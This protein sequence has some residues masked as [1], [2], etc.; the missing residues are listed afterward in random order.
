VRLLL[1]KI[2]PRILLTI[3]IQMLLNSVTCRLNL[4]FDY[5]FHQLL[6]WFIYIRGSSL[7][8]QQPLELLRVHIPLKVKACDAESALVTASENLAGWAV[9]STTVQRTAGL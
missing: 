8:F 7:S 6:V 4:A 5:L 9:D 2:T 3:Q 1:Y